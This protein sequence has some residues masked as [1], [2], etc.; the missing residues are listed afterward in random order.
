ML[1]VEHLY[2]HYGK[3]TVVQD[4]SFTVGQGE[5]VGLLGPNG[6]GKTT[7][8]Y[9]VVGVVQPSSGLVKLHGNELT[10]L[11]MHERTLNG[12]GYLP[13]ETSVF[14]GLSTLE[15]LLLVLELQGLSPPQQR[16]EA[17]RLLEEFGLTK[18]AHTLAIRLSGGERRRLELARA[19][20]AN[21]QLLLLDEPFT[22]IDPITIEEL[23]QVLQ[24]LRQER[25]LSILITDHNP[26]A[27]LKLVDRAYIMFDGHVVFE[28]DTQAIAHSDMVKSLYLGEGF[29][30]V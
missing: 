27:T 18:L 20:A 7:S 25:Q 1:T 3:R 23:Q 10:K 17:H 30:L 14:R 13:Q 15:N 11:P 4:V 26:Q 22:G 8:F 9:M 5:I 16:E 29:Q 6:A 21:P 28:G 12:L 2:K 24:R 19:L